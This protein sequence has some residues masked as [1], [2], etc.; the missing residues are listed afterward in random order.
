M[1]FAPSDGRKAVMPLRRP[2]PLMPRLPQKSPARMQMHARPARVTWIP[3]FFP[4]LRPNGR[5]QDLTRP[6]GVVLLI[7]VGRGCVPARPEGVAVPHRVPPKDS[8]AR[9]AVPHPQ[10]FEVQRSR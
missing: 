3:E 8:E 10:R 2:H 6:A 5:G 1:R 9:E 7:P 4:L